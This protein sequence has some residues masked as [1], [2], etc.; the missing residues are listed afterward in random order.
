MTNDNRAV[1]YRM[2]MK[3]HICP[4]GLKA[5]DLLERKNFSVVDHQLTSRA[6]TEK[7]KQ[8]HNVETTPQAF[9]HG[10]RIGGYDAL[11]KFLGVDDK[12]HCSRTYMPTI[13]IFLMAFLMSLVINWAIIQD[14]NIIKIIE[15]FISLSMCILAIQKLRDLESFTNQFLGYDLLAQKFVRYA[16]MYPFGEAV[17]GLGMLAGGLLGV[18]VSPIAILIGGIGAASVFKAVYINKHDLKCACVGGNS[19]VPLGMISLIENIMMVGMGFWMI[20]KMV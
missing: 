3:E 11:R 6:E 4:F 10:E 15:I 13:V 2:V 1:L 5:K 16:Y 19:K 9:I 17:A 20:I 14:F 7:F 18:I 8:E 12:E